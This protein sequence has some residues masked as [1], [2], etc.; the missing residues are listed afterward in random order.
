MQEHSKVKSLKNEELTIVLQVY[1]RSCS[2]RLLT[3]LS[4]ELDLRQKIQFQIERCD[5]NS[6][7][8]HSIFFVS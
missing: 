3:Q 5:V 1:I 8:I 2:F 7:E 4:T 6:V